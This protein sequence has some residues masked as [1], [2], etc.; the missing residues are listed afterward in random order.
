[1]L[2]VGTMLYFVDRM[3]LLLL[4]ISSKMNLKVLISFSVVIDFFSLIKADHEY[5]DHASESSSENS[6]NYFGEDPDSSRL[7][8][9]HYCITN[10]SKLEYKLEIFEKLTGIFHF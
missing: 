2:D 4:T 8:I 7:S 5:G 6:D 9:L 1:M 3:K 10:I